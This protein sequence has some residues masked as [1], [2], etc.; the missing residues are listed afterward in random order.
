MLP[1]R[2]LITALSAFVL[3]GACRPAYLERIAPLQGPELYRTAMVE[4]ENERWSNAIT[5]FER[6]S[7]ELPARDSLLAR[8]YFYLGQAHVERRE[9]LLAAQSFQRIPET[10]PNDT[11]ADDGLLHAGRAYASMWR[12]PELDHEYGQTALST[13]ETLLAVY[14]NSDVRAQAE[15]ARREVMAQLA[16]KDY[17]TGVYYIRRR[18][19]DSAILYLEG[20]LERYPETPITRRAR[21]RLV[22]VYERLNYEAEARE[23]CEALRRLHP[24]DEEVREA[25]GAASDARS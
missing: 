23:T 2:S 10:F 22:D 14:P 21:L 1:I 15:E 19:Y 7:R 24:G 9:Y 4:F 8:V 17:N 11:L 16:E 12:K 3:L 6:L 25:C 13:F 5:A 20:V 18:A